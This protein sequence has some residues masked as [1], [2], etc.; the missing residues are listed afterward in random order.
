MKAIKKIMVAVLLSLSMVV[1]FVPINVFAADTP[2]FSGGKGTQEEPWLISSREDLIELADWVNSEKAK[3]FDIDDCGM[4]YFH[5][6][7]FKQMANIDLT[8]VDYEPIG[9]TDEAYFSGNYDGNNFIVSNATSTGK[10]DSYGQA[11]VGIFGFIAEAKIENV[12]VKN[13]NFSATGKLAY[14]IAGGLVGASL[15]SSITNCFVEDSV[16]ESNRKPDANN[17]AGGIVGLSSGGSL[18]KCISNNNII[19]SHAYG[20]GLVGEISDDYDDMIAIKDCA[21]ANCK[22]TTMVANGQGTSYAGGFVGG[23]FFN[24]AEVTNCYVY[25]TNIVTQKGTYTGTG[26]YFG[27]V[28]RNG[29]YTSDINMTNCYYGE[30]GSVSDN[31]FTA[32]SKSKEEFENGTVAGL[33]GNSFVQNGSNITLKTYPADYTKVNE[34]K[35]KVPTDLS[36]YTEETVKSL[37]DALD[38]VV[39]RKSVAE[40]T[41][42][43]S[44]A[45]A[46]NKAI[47]ELKY[48]DADYTKVNEAKAKVPSD[49]S[50]YTD[51]TIEALKDALALVEE[52]K[53]ITEQATVDG[54]ADAINKAIEGLVKKK[55]DKNE[56]P[57]KDNNNE[58]KDLT[59][60]NQET[61]KPTVR[62][63]KTMVKTENK[64][65]VKKVKTG[66]DENIVGVTLLLIGSLVVL[67]YI[68]KK[69]I[70]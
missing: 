54:Y 33:L 42:V 25:N 10:Q 36:V 15:G 39:E 48:K 14:G 6:Y 29:S 13:V 2:T 56:T 8:G 68:R 63:T 46:I 45:D 17:C 53:N 64:E 49:L 35:S 41:T 55:D 58:K 4:G 30:C 67:T 7:Y 43:D 60:N 3:T 28:Y 24:T 66:D 11:T 19:T 59:S 9:Y 1:S 65:E 62:E 12:Y 31:I 26:V 38:T 50:I 34:A 51:E 57:V 16:I 18:E 22:V 27:D 61:V 70:D 47:S 20:G 40:Q 5:G 21:V 44:Y 32:S 69:K 37:K 52:G 23:I